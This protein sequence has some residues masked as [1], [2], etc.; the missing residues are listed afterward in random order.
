MKKSILIISLIVL[1]FAT[2]ASAQSRAV[3]ESTYT[4]PYAKAYQSEGVWIG[5]KGRVR[6][7]IVTY[8]VARHGGVANASGLIDTG[9]TI[10]DNAIVVDGLM[11]VIVGTVPTDTT[12]ALQLNTGND[13]YSAST[14]TSLISIISTV[15]LLMI[16]NSSLMSIKLPLSYI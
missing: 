13:V 10:P 9:I 7:D 16:F 3:L 14:N 11:D 2:F 15:P 4:P 6:Y 12:V 5:E 8:S 1:G